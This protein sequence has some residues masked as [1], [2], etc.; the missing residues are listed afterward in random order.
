MNWDKIP[1][2]KMAIQKQCE[3]AKLNFDLVDYIS[4]KL[5]FEENV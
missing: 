3:I 5:Y 1:Y 4:G 2:T